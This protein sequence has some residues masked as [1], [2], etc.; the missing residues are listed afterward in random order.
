MST[1]T[2]T[3]ARCG[4]PAEGFARINGKAYCHGD[5]DERYVTCYQHVSWDAPLTSRWLPQ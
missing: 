1:A 3:C 5:G 2:P 4:K